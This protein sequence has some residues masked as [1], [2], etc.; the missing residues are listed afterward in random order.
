MTTAEFYKTE[1]MN[2]KTSSSKKAFLTRSKN[3]VIEY[4]NDVKEALNRTPSWLHG[5]IMTDKHR[6]DLEYEILL[7]NKIYK[8]L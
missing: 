3:S 5:D 2:Y 4:L 7:I 6:S 1:I 8:T